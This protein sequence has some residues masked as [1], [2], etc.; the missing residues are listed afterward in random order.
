MEPL[1]R[2]Y[3]KALL[4]ELQGPKTIWAYMLMMTEV[5]RPSHKLDGIRKRILEHVAVA[6][7]QVHA[8]VDAAGNILLRKKA[9]P[10]MEHLPGICIQGHLDMVP[11]KVDGLEFDFEKQ[12]IEPKIQG[13]WLVCAWPFS[14]LLKHLQQ[15]WPQRPFL[16]G[17][18]PVCV[19]LCLQGASARVRF[20]AASG[21]SMNPL[22]AP[23]Q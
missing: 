21:I 8:K 5:P 17:Y 15:T 14:C 16:G 18:A 23:P 3:T 1:T 19:R 13:D 22:S 4:K 10:G 11:T 9:T 2:P 7:P 12:A 20:S 6:M